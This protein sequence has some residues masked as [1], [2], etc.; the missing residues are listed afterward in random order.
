MRPSQSPRDPH[1]DF[2]KIDH[3]FAVRA[4]PAAS[5]SG[6]GIQ[7]QARVFLVL[8]MEGRRQSVLVEHTPFVIGRS[9]ECNLVL[10]YADTSRRHAQIDMGPDGQWMLR[11]L[12][13]SNGT[14]LNGRT[15]KAP[16][17]L[18]VND[19]ILIPPATLHLEVDAAKPVRQEVPVEPCT[20]LGQAEWEFL[21]AIHDALEKHAGDFPACAKAVCDAL[22]G[23]AFGAVAAAVVERPSYVG[24]PWTS[25]HEA[26]PA[27]ACVLPPF[28]EVLDDAGCPCSES[29]DALVHRRAASGK[30]VLGHPLPAGR[31]L[32]AV[33]PS[34]AC[35]FGH[36]RILFSVAGGLLAQWSMPGTRTPHATFR[37][38]PSWID[39]SSAA[40]SPPGP[41]MHA[42]IA[43]SAGDQPLQFLAL[44]LDGAASGRG[45]ALLPALLAAEV[46]LGGRF[47]R[48]EDLVEFGRRF[49]AGHFPERA[50]DGLAAALIP[51][52]GGEAQV[53]VGGFAHAF[54][55]T[56]GQPDRERSCACDS[57]ALPFDLGDVLILRAGEADRLAG[58]AKGTSARAAAQAWAANGVAV[59]CLRM[60]KV[61]I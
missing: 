7:P 46:A 44:S 30:H 35:L 37:R 16:C 54:V 36:H 52:E 17:V 51:M 22:M 31:A 34:K 1:S 28:L 18:R 32:V 8:E 24:A 45:P 53:S 50:V 58:K 19:T 60:P 56:N 15:V 12:E 26:G 38:V 10:P 48:A 61:D 3:R 6:A 47:L 55:A 25:L 14:L 21:T 40:G 49:A 57:A 42:A 41:R 20:P 5:R 43:Q 11:D 39:A 29:L 13:S 27:G 4:G 59:A 33:A 2:T 23:P 9:R